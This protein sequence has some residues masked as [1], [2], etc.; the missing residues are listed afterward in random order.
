MIERPND[1]FD[2]SLVDAFLEQL[3]PDEEELFET[4]VRRN[5]INFHSPSDD[6]CIVAATDDDEAVPVEGPLRRLLRIGRADARFER[7][8]H[9]YALQILERELADAPMRALLADP[10]GP[11]AYRTA[12]DELLRHA[13]AVPGVRAAAYGLT[14]PMDRTGG[15]RCC[16]RT[17][18]R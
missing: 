6:A 18:P 3:D 4:M 5:A 17:T 15:S 1:N 12:M 9:P 16:W 2:F 8:E 7:H 14:A 11:D 13:A 10:D